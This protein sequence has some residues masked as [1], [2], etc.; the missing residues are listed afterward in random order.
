MINVTLT[1]PFR[2]V[3]S[4]DRPKVNYAVLSKGHKLGPYEILDQLGAGGMGEVYLAHDTAL[5]REV[6]IKVL[7]DAFAQD[8]ERMKRF[9]REA[10]VLATLN[11]P[12]IAQVYG[13]EGKALVMEYVPGASPRGP[14]LVEDALG[15]AKQLADGL[16]AA[17][18]KGIVHRDLKPDNLKVTPQGRLKVL[19]FGLAKAMEE[20]PSAASSDSPTMSLA[21][22]KTGAILGTPYYMSPEQARGKAA[23]QRADIWAFG[24]ILYELLTG[25]R[26]FT[27]ETRSDILAALLTG[28]VDWSALPADAPASVKELLRRCLERDPKRRLRDIGDAR[29]E[30]EDALAAPAA[31]AAPAKIHEKSNR[32]V[33]VAAGMSLASAILVAAWLVVRPKPSAPR[34]VSVER[35]TDLIGVE[36]TP[37]ASPDGKTVAF[38]APAA[39]KRQIW[40]RLLAAGSSLQLTHEPVDHLNPRWSPDSSSLIYYTAS[41]S[42]AEQG[43]IW[44]VAALGGAPRRIASALGGGDISHDGRHLALFRLGAKGVELAVLS[45]DGSSTERVL[46]PPNQAIYDLPRW[47]PDDSM[48]AFHEGQSLSFHQAIYAIPLTGGR[49]IQVA[50][51]EYQQG[52]SWLS[53]GSGLVYSSSRGSTVLYPPV[54]NL[55]TA[56]LDGHQDRQITFGEFSY[57]EPDM[58]PS[59]KLFASRIRRQAD[60][61]KIPMSG[62][63]ADNA[64]NAMRITHQTGQAQTPSLSPDGKELVYLS[65]NGGHGNLWIVKTDGSG[66]RQITF[67]RSPEVSIGVPIWSPVSPQIVFIVSREGGTSEWLINSDGSGLHQLV[68][69]AASAYWSADG[70]WIYYG[71]ND[72]PAPFCISRVS[73]AGGSPASVRCENAS[74]TFG[75]PDSSTLYYATQTG[76]SSGGWDFDIFRARPQNGVPEKLSHVSGD[77]V[78]ITSALFQLQLSPDGKLL[79]GPFLDGTTCNLWA[80]PSSGGPLRRLTDFGERSLLIARRISWTKD[81]RYIYAALADTDADV[82]LLKGLLP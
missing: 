41:E 50:A 30:V 8:A 19:D 23:D 56:S 16:E 32:L 47:S 17:H 46:P 73:V 71:P 64:R 63:P 10:Q 9:Q 31:P 70:Q 7:P 3:K 69:S 35:I 1:Q 37:A 14:M 60:I 59:G 22:T 27:G 61:W 62:S 6:A 18:E 53:D 26:P 81:S 82:V 21:A 52:L 39:G 28:A 79:A 44:E 13:M 58:G 67:E 77:R 2:L 33:W 15:L 38:V 55:R 57:V 20:T 12:N 25:A 74:I 29:I 75:I 65:D 45:R 72:R 5:N 80:M 24:V 78:P 48:L 34:E 76:G 42:A 36:E 51:G 4:S 49:P 43:T 40:I 66:A 11:H 54:F 68:T